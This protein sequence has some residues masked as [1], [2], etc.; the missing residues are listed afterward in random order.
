MPDNA[1][2]GVTRTSMT[3][4]H[5]NTTHPCFH[6]LPTLMC[7]LAQAKTEDRDSSIPK[8]PKYGAKQ[9]AHT[10]GIEEP[11]AIVLRHSPVGGTVLLEDCVELHHEGL[12]VL[13]VKLQRLSAL[14]RAAELIQQL[15]ILPATTRVRNRFSQL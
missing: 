1:T 14:L 15:V 10:D 13:A 5:S 3:A 7:K 4:L 2:D 12:R 9:E 6:M 8:S 11:H